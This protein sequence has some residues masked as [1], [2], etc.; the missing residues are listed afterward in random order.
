MNCPRSLDSPMLALLSTE[1]PTFAEYGPAA[2][3]EASE[4]APA[5]APDEPQEHIV[6]VMRRCGNL[7]TLFCQY[8]SCTRNGRE[9]RRHGVAPAPFL[10]CKY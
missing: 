5:E 10:S 6:E 3:E 8:S 2:S 7:Y 1:M 4:E 9:R